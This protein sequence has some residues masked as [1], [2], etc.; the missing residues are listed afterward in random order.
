MKA[1]IAF[2]ILLALAVAAGAQS[3]SGAT[4]L[5]LSKGPALIT[6]YCSACHGWAADYDSIMASGAI[7]PGKSAS[8]RAWFM[9]SSGRMPQGGP[10][11]PAKDRKIIY[12]W[13]AAGAPRPL[14]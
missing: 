12:D 5:R 14:K 1:T 10:P 2:T 13:I 11:L 9:I 8:S 3:A 6:A 4:T 7:V